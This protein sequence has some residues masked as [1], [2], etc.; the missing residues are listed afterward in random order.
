MRPVRRR[1]GARAALV[2]VLAL[3]LTSCGES[4]FNG[5]YN[6][7]LPG[8]ADLGDHPYRITAQFSD[9]LDLVPQASVKVSDVA[10]GRVER[11]EL[12]P[13]TTFATVTMMVNGTVELPANARADLRQSSLL[14]EKFVE[15]SAPEPQQASGSLD[16]G[17]VIPLARTSRHAELEEVLGAL[18][19]L[20]SGGGV[21][22]LRSIAQEL[23]DALSGNEAEIRSMLSRV[24][25]LV[26]ELDGQK[27]EI[28]R[29]I[30]GLDRLAATLVREKRDL[31]NALDNL[32]PGLR[33][34]AEQRDQIVGMLESLHTLSDVTVDTIGRSKRQMVDNLRA[35]EPTLRKLADAGKDLPIALKILPM[36]PLPWN[37]GDVA[38]GDF[39]NVD[40]RFKLNF[41]ELIENMNNAGRPA[42]GFA[43]EQ[44]PAAGPPQGELPLPGVLPPLNGSALPGPTPS[45]GND[46]IGLLGSLMGAGR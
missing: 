43:P 45:D 30:D 2:L 3:L 31:T 25:H 41:D 6:T 7:P 12:S 42:F 26:T 38:K 9:V 44:E 19:L 37:A 24:D 4:G 46:P 16:D 13:D 35:L 40:V 33:V 17:A 15:L 5:L 10:V 29:A 27:G 1:L 36:Y 22:Q 39:A 8:G 28:V 18:S 23:N 20:L 21:E 34:V 11:I 32:S 14:G